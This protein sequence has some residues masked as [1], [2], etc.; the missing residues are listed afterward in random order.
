MCVRECLCVAR[1]V[2]QEVLPL[3][4]VVGG[5][6][7]AAATQLGL[8]TGLPVAQGGAGERASQQEGPC[9]LS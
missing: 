7:E 9:N 5:L 1:G 6:T 2:L 3:G 8:P 4:A